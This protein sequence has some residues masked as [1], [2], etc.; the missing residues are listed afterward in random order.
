MPLSNSGSTSP[1]QC[2]PSVRSTSRPVATQS[3][4]SAHKSRGV[5]VIGRGLG[6][7]EAYI[8]FAKR[9]SRNADRL[10]ELRTR[11]NGKGGH[12]HQDVQGHGGREKPNCK[13]H[14]PPKPPKGKKRKLVLIENAESTPFSRAWDRFRRAVLDE[15]AISV[16]EVA[17]KLWSIY[18]PAALRKK[19]RRL[20]PAALASVP[21]EMWID[22][23]D[24]PTLAK[25][26]YALGCLRWELDDEKGAIDAFR[27]TQ[28][29]PDGQWALADSLLW[30][31][32]A[33]EAEQ[34]LRVIAD[35]AGPYGP[36][37]RVLLATELSDSGAASSSDYEA[38]AQVS[39]ALFREGPSQRNFE[40]ALRQRSQVDQPI[41][42]VENPRDAS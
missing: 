20:G 42:R 13:R 15:P 23:L 26:A 9:R 11:K 28:G 14:T 16:L 37:A 18:R 33:E 17:A 41:D 35:S 40:R 3:T 32:Q 10:N 29:L 25:R 19:V 22:I 34:H 6:I 30:A 1:R 8:G 5:G 36:L 2:V 39:A 7:S 21:A 38:A 31:G 24:A 12:R 27:L 4:G